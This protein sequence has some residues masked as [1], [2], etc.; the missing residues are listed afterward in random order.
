[1]NNGSTIKK[2]ITIDIKD[3]PKAH[4]LLINNLLPNRLTEQEID[5]LAAFINLD[6]DVVTVSGLFG[7]ISRKQVRDK[8]GLKSA[9]HLGNII[10]SLKKKNYIYEED[11]ELKIRNYL[12]V[13]PEEK[14]SGEEYFLV[15]SFKVTTNNGKN[16]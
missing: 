6:K 12:V 9:A 15:Y 14:I 3:F 7:T 8:V 2:D 4:L 11:G 16:K 5:T 10:K 13:K 1:M